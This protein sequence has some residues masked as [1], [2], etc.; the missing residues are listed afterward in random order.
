MSSHA[1]PGDDHRREAFG[2]LPIMGFALA[3]LTAS[4]TQCRAASKSATA[5]T[6][7]RP[8]VEIDHQ[9]ET[10][11]VEALDVMAD[12]LDCVR[13]MEQDQPTDH[14]DERVIVVKRPDVGLD[15]ANV[16]D[17]GSDPV[18]LRS[19]DH[20]RGLIDSRHRTSGRNQTVQRRRCART[21]P[22][23]WRC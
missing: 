16:L 18:L 17:A 21:T 22:S 1:E 13:K 2:N 23:A 12:H 11:L 6:S 20:R 14:R 4:I 8:D 7:C 9:H 19:T 3:R 15:E 5:G 10:A